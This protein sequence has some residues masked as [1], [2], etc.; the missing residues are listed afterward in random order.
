MCVLL[1]WIMVTSAPCS[2]RAA[3]MSCAELLEPSTTAFLPAYFSG[4]GCLLEW[5]WSP[6]KFSAPG[7]LGTLG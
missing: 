4:P 7:I 1:R 6:R 5:C 3:Q 2:H